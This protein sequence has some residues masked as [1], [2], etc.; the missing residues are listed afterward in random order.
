MSKKLTLGVFC[1]AGAFRGMYHCGFLQAL[2]EN[3][4]PTHQLVGASS[5]FYAILSH[6]AGYQS[7]D[8]WAKDPESPVFTHPWHKY[9]LFDNFCK[10]VTDKMFA[11]SPYS[12]E[13]IINRLNEKCGALVTRIHLLS[14]DVITKFRNKDHV[15]EVVKATGSMPYFLSDFPRK[16]DGKKYI[17][18]GVSFRD[19]FRYL[20]TDIKV[21]LST[22]SDKSH[23]K[24][25]V[26]E[27]KYEFKL[28]YP[29][30]IKNAVWGEPEDYVKMWN[31][32]FSDGYMFVERFNIRE[33]VVGDQ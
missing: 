13:E 22:L 5:G 15:V 18:G 19:S 7:S 33:Q 17:D 8:F 2:K 32:G 6:V 20:N 24:Y 29:N 16:L 12:E 23:K 28:N 14:D 9:R 3:G 11:E 26:G 27:N 10:H 30:P 1:E 25:V 4:I 31:Q 21:K